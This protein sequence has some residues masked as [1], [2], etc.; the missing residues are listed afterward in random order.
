MS[1][2]WVE[3]PLLPGYVLS[4]YAIVLLEKGFIHGCPEPALGKDTAGRPAWW[5]RPIGTPATIMVRVDGLG[6]LFADAQAQ[7]SGHREGGHQDQ[8]VV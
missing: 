1:R 5:I 4:R 6:A 8:D 2:S 3:H 7:A